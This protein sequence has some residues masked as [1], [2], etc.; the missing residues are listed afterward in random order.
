MKEIGKIILRTKKE[1][2]VLVAPLDWGL[3]H[4]TRCIPLIQ[5]LLNAGFE[6]IIAGEKQQKSLLQREFPLLEFKELRGYRL[7]Y[8]KNNWSTT[9]K[10]ILQIPKILI[11]INREKRWLRTISTSENLDAVISDNRYGLHNP[12]IL[13]ILITHQLVIQTPF[14]KGVQRTL[15]DINYRVINR[16][17]HCWVPDSDSISNLGGELSHPSRLPVCGVFYIGWLS[18]FLKLPGLPV[19]FDILILI[20]GPEPQRTIFEKLL[21]D[22]LSGYKGKAVVLRGLPGNNEQLAVA[23]HI[24]IHNH[25]PSEELNKLV[26]GAGIVISRSGYSTVMD[27][28]KMGKKSILVPTPGQTEQEYLAEYL[29]HQ[30]IAYTTSQ[31]EFSLQTAL[32]AARL[33][34]FLHPKDDA[35]VAMRSA[36][37]ALKNCFVN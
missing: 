15:Q 23:G 3:G 18:R 4:A 2:K 22:E 33:F 7:I 5:E 19:Y 20:S 6:V 21:L 31:R 13:S 8:G 16:F 1:P 25:L 36:V 30:K 17:T 28:V 11:Q 29:L 9:I 32:E 35:G 14:G 24:A 10:I 26:A 37:T 27:L 34:P 12:N